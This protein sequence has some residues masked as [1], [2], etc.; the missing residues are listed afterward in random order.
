MDCPYQQTPQ[1]VLPCLCTPD[2]GVNLWGAAFFGKASPL[3]E[4][5][6]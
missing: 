1:A 6:T 5:G 4:N 2:M 3:Y